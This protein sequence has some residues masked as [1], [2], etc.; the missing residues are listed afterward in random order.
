MGCARVRCPSFSL[1]A[2]TLSVRLRGFNLQ[3]H[4]CAAA[5][6]ARHGEHPFPREAPS[7]PSQ[8][9]SPSRASPFRDVHP[10]ALLSLMHELHRNRIVRH[11][12]ICLYF[13]SLNIFLDLSMGF[14][15]LRS[16]NSNKKI[17]IREF[18]CPGSYESHFRFL[19]R[20]HVVHQFSS[21]CTLSYV[22]TSYYILHC[23][24]PLPT[25]EDCPISQSAIALESCIRMEAKCFV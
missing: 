6:G 15:S 3:T 17:R 24:S 25:A 19:I 21:Q 12:L 14:S 20:L 11:L 5:P 2:Q 7:A 22:P 23:I 13:L 10:Y 1:N 8:S 18:L 9:V 4:T 16:L